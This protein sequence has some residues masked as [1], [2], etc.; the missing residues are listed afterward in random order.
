MNKYFIYHKEYLGDDYET[1]EALNHED[2]AEKY[3]KYY[4]EYENLLIDG[5]TL[6]INVKNEKGKIKKFN[7]GTKTN[8][9]YTLKE[10]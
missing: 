7:V 6:I 8:I 3:A 2:A 4:N 5:D 10:L 9:I 1:I